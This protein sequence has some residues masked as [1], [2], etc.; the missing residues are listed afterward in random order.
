VRRFGAD[1]WSVLERSPI[2]PWPDDGEDWHRSL[3]RLGWAEFCRVGRAAQDV[4]GGDGSPLHLLIV[5][6]PNTLED[7][8]FLIEVNGNLSEHCEQVAVQDLPSLMDLLAKWAPTLESTA[9]ANLAAALP[10]DPGQ[11]G[12]LT[13][14][15]PAHGDG[16]GPD[17][18]PARWKLLWPVS[19]RTLSTGARRV[20]GGPAQA[21]S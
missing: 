6:R 2:E 1:G 4:V 5:H 20:D 11:L 7:P 15:A 8:Q 18:R 12:H 14:A 3:A 16:P 17:R 21:R 10:T 9:A 13:S 19:L